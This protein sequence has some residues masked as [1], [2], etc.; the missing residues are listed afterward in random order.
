MSFA[1]LVTLVVVWSSHVK[2][3]QQHTCLDRWND[4]K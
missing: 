3:K 2:K 4:W 1:R